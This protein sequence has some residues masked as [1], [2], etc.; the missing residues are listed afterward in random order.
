MCIIKFYIQQGYK[1][2]DM[3][4]S[5]KNETSTRRVRY[6]FNVYMLRMVVKMT[7]VSLRNMYDNAN[8]TV[9]IFSFC[10]QMSLH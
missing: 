3:I 9:T 8:D 2:Y 6:F 7:K 4:K 10:M 5:L 1:I